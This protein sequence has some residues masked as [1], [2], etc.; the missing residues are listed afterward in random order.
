MEMIY[1]EAGYGALSLHLL[2]T[3]INTCFTLFNNSIA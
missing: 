2:K 1:N 3:E